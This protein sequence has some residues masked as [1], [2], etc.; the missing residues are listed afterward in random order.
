MKLSKEDLYNILS[1]IGKYIED[2]TDMV[3]VFELKE[4]EKKLELL[5]KSYK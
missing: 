1:I 3:E 2:S 4:L 5:V